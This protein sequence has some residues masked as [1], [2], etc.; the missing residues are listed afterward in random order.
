M[1]SF[2]GPKVVLGISIPDLSTEILDLEK[3]GEMLPE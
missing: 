3:I 2:D 1:M